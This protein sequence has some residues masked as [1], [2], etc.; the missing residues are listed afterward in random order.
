MKKKPIVLDFTNT[1]A[2]ED[3]FNEAFQH[4]R[5]TYVVQPVDVDIATEW[6]KKNTNM[7][8]FVWCAGVKSFEKRLEEAGPLH[9]REIIHLDELYYRNRCGWAAGDWHCDHPNDEHSEECQEKG[10]EECEELEP[11]KAGEPQHKRLCSAWNCPIASEADRDDIRKLYP[12][13]YRS[14]YE[15]YPDAEPHDWMVLHSRPRYAYV[16]NIQVLGCE[17]VRRL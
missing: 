7:V 11:D 16:P 8:N 14:D 2:V 15:P 6:L 17:Q 9:L 3:L 13:L 4:P 5:R 1:Q 12:D 10:C